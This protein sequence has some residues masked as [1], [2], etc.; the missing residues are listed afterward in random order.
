MFEPPLFTK[1]KSGTGFLKYPGCAAAYECY[2][3]AD[4]HCAPEW[5]CMQSVAMPQFKARG[6]LGG[7]WARGGGQCSP[8]IA[9]CA[10]VD[11]A[12]ALPRFQGANG[13]MRVRCD[14]LARAA[15]NA[16]AHSCVQPQRYSL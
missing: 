5:R 2:C 14:C 8:L 4:E 13:G 9:L 15:S 1:V 16:R 7:P 3:S 11:L 10:Q 12:A 6:L